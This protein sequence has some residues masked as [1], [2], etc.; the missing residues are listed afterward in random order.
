M[1]T[2]LYLHQGAVLGGRFHTFMGHNCSGQN[3][4]HYVYDPATDTWTGS[5]S[6]PY[7]AYWPV[8]AQLPGSALIMSGWNG[9]N[10]VNVYEYLAP[11]FL[12]GKQ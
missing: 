1:P 2:A 10:V 3:N 8:V 9:P 5:A 7:T 12:Y 4:Y 11:L 6:I